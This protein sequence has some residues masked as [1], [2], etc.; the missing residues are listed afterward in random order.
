MDY[1]GYVFGNIKVIKR[2]EGD[3]ERCRKSKKEKGTTTNPVYTCECLLCGKIFNRNIYAIK[4]N[5]FQNC[6]CQSL[7]YDLSGKKFGKLLAIRPVG[8]DEHKE[9]N[10]ACKCD[11][12]NTYVA[13]SYSLRIGHTTQCRECS[14]KQIADRNRKYLLLNEKEVEHHKKNGQ[15]TLLYCPKRLRS[16]YTNMKTRCYNPNSKSYNNYGG[17]GIT[18]CDEWQNDFVVF[19]QWAMA[20]GYADGLTIDRIDNNGNYEP[21]NCRFV[22]R[23]E[24]SNNR[25]SNLYIEY[26]GEKDTLS[27]WA[28]R[29]SIPYYYIQY[30][31]YKG[32][33]MES[34]VNEF[35]NGT[36]RK[37]KTR[38]TQ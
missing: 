30:R 22:S 6:G 20:N 25:R 35:N 27:N 28:M 26:I 8:L 15:D 1:S 12:G 31:L 36:R 23:L 29:L 14:L 3:L 2:A 32:M 18:V 21:N 37:R 13:K 4:N 38:Q 11:C 17:R 34:I 24:Q 7:Q 5:K 33:D 10:W 9:M 16:V 19:A